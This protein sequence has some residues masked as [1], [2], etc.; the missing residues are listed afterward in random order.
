MNRNQLFQQIR[1][2]QSFLCIGLDSD[3]QKLPAHLKD[4]EDPVFEFNK[5]IVDYTHHLAVAY[6]PNTAFYEVNASTGWTSLEKTARYIKDNYP[7]VLLIADAKRGDIGNTSAMYA[8]TF[9]ETMN[10]DAVTLS[11]FMGLDT[12]EPFLQY[13]D[14]WSIVLALT[15]NKSA[16]DFQYVKDEKTGKFLFETVLNISRKWGTTDQMMYVVGATKA[17]SLLEVRKIVPDHFLL[18]PGIGAQG[19][20]LKEV[21]QN[22]MNDHCGLLVNS[23]RGIIFASSGTDFAIA[24]QQ[25][26]EIVQ[27]EMAIYLQESGLL[28]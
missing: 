11:P 18:V 23:S 28:D 27:N 10:F 3:I 13:K 7:D 2:K 5:Q 6:K 9:F 26:A 1:L 22:G 19:G 20:S 24:A 25:E 16:T 8:R 14:R 15:S 17:E 21:A 12:V 4:F